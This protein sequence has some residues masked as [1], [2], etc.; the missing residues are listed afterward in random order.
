[1]TQLKVPDPSDHIRFKF[2]EC[3][4]DPFCL[5]TGVFKWFNLILLYNL[6]VYMKIQSRSTHVKILNI[7]FSL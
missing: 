2:S 1:M 6:Y 4:R 3:K 7:F 5:W